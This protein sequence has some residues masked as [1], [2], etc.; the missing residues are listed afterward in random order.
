MTLAIVGEEGAARLAGLDLET[1]FATARP[2]LVRLARSLGGGDAAEDA[3]HDAYLI[4]RARVGGL[5]D[6]GAIDAWLDRIVVHRCFR[7]RRRRLRL[8]ELLPSLVRAR[9]APR[10]ELRELIERLP[11]RQRAAI[12]LH[13]GHGYSL[14][15]V[16]EMLGIGYDNARA[17]VS[18]ARRRLY[19][20]WTEAEG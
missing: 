11:E 10:L 13:Y 17:V 15:E 6:A 19:D 1:A 20:Q 14:G 2:R 12:V 16:A 5:R 4:A 9:P 7:L 8:D 3:V 18:R